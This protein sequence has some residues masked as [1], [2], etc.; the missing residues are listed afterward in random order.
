MKKV[1]VTM[2]KLSTWLVLSA[3]SI[4]FSLFLGIAGAIWRLCFIAI[5]VGI[6]VMLLWNCVCPALFN[7]PE[8]TF[9]Q[10]TGLYLL[11]QLLTS[12]QS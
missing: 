9:W 1:V 3:L 11:I 5:F 7:L 12:K 6:P 10:A 4:L 2:K 8:M